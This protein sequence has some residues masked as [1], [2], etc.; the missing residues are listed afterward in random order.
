V[1]AIGWVWWRFIGVGPVEWLLGWV[2]LRP[3]RWRRDRT[4]SAVEGASTGG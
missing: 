4:S 3:K 2:T 1:T